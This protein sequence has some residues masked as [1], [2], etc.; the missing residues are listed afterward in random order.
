MDDET[1][2]KEPGEEKETDLTKLYQK[3]E[4]LKGKLDKASD[5]HLVLS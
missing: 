1:I 2:K 4:L 5:R 3:L